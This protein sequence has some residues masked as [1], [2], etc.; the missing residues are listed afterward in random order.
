MD[1]ARKNEYRQKLL[2]LVPQSGGIGNSSLR[3]ALRAVLESSGE[4]I[5]E[6]D[7]WTLRDSLIDEGLIETGRGRGG[8]VRR[9]EPPT[10]AVPVGP[11]LDLYE[12]FHTSIR[13]GYAR[14]NRIKRFVSEVT[15]LQGRRATGGKWTRPDLTVL[16][17]RTYS[18]LPGKHLEVITFEVKPS[19][20]VAI[21]GVFEA[22]AHSVFAHRS[23]L[24]VRIPDQGDH[25]LDNNRAF[26]ECK[27]LGVGYMTF[28]DANDYD[29]FDIVTSARLNDP[30]P[31]EVDN[32]IRTQISP[33]NHDELR[34]WLR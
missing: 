34:E 13:T 5:T 27:R 3:Q 1:A 19:L 10:T 14:A 2:D 24:A 29:T 28:I 18:F 15:A 21:E 6:E 16:A 7:Y 22:L 9:P 20:E 17:M 30:D 8:S 12:P 31:Y 11:E 26:Q 23:F 32:F 25:D 4:Q 33:Q